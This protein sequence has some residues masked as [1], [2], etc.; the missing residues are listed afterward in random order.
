ML[1]LGLAKCFNCA[2]HALVSSAI[3]NLLTFLVDWVGDDQAP[4]AN[5]KKNRRTAAKS[6]VMRH[7]QPLVVNKQSGA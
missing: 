1:F 4:L 5:R 3:L 2:E 7:N 6:K